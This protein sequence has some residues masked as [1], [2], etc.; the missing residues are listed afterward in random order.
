MG[1]SRRRLDALAFAPAGAP[2]AAGP[3]P[4]GW[5]EKR[6]IPRAVDTEKFQG[7]GGI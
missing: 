1:R 5:R 4:V 7:R 3:A 6:E 2:A